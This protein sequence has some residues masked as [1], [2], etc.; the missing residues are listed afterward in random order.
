MTFWKILT[1]I[2][3]VSV[4]A[5]SKWSHRHKRE[6]HSSICDPVQNSTDI[7]QCYCA[8]LTHH[9]DQISTAECYQT[10]KNVSQYHPSWNRFTSLQNISRLTLTNTRGVAMNYI[11]TNALKYT[12]AILRLDVK[13]C[14]IDKLESY[15]F[16]NLSLIE[17]MTLR[18]NQIRIMAE[19]AFAHHARLK[20][21]SLDQNNIAEIYRNV[22]IDLPSLEQLFL[23]AN[24]ITTIHDRAFVH[25]TNL[26]ELEID[27][28]SLFS[29]NSET[30]SGLNNLEK[31]ELSGNSLEVVG[32][33]TF[34]PL[35]NLRFL[36]LGGNKIQMLDEKAFNGLA[37][38]Q[39][40]SLEHNKLS[41]LENEKFFDGLESLTSLSLK[42]NGISVIKPEVI[43]PILSNFY[44]KTSQ[45]NIEGNIL[46][47]DCRL[48]VFRPI[49]NKTQNARL[50]IDIQNLQCHPNDEVKQKWDR[51]QET[52]KNTGQ[53]FEDVEPQ[54]DNTAYEYYDETDLNG[55][56]F[57]FD[58]R[59]ILNCSG[60]ERLSKPDVPATSITKQ[61]HKPASRNDPINNFNAKVTSSPLNNIVSTTIKPVVKKHIPIE[62]DNHDLLD[63]SLDEAT[64]EDPNEKSRQDYSNTVNIDKPTRYKPT[65]GSNHEVRNDKKDTV[66]TTS[67]LATVSAKPVE[68]KHY[69]DQD[70]ASDEAKPD[71]LKAHRSIQEEVKESSNLNIN[72]AHKD[73][74]CI[75]LLISVIFSLLLFL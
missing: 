35:L 31:L 29:L 8:R 61:F 44:G 32:D 22:F 41:T 12:K 46:D 6:I 7:V 24:K 59:Y 57:Y 20:T 64:E 4:Y 26:K 72:N 47:C 48:D 34:A 55:T 40:L 39:V 62:I 28:N 58:M 33:N 51:I 60:E 16:A 50:S 49:Q 52:A 10:A 3:A 36:N 56:I 15:A 45:L 65:H 68:S 74:G 30:F 11:P 38:L 73:D 71:R 19:N 66:Y 2:C 21:I 63:L 43:L 13:Y 25:L 17:E 37:R 53:V 54:G 18:D 1:V 14:N 75:P 70:M 5:E 27:K 23:T 42:D 69:E 67:R 9:P